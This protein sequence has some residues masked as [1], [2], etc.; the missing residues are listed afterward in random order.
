MHQTIADILRVLNANDPPTADEAA[1]EIMD[2]VIATCVHATRFAVNRQIQASPGGLVFN[3]D[4]LLDIPLI[5]YYESIQGI[6]QQLIDKNLM[7]SNRKRIDYNYNIGDKLYIK[8]YDPTKM[9]QRYHG[10]YHVQRVYN[11]GN[12]GVRMN[13]NTVDR[14]NIRNLVLY[15]GQT[16]N[17]D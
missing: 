11:N 16:Y 10:P 8:E 3:R 12:L 9:M 2:S 1:D 15:R 14:N 4:M 5:A 6:R 17:N 13:D 7:R